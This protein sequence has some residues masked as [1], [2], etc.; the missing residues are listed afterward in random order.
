VITAVNFG[1]PKFTTGT[2]KFAD[3]GEELIRPEGAI[4]IRR[5]RPVD[6]GEYTAT[7]E[8]GKPPVESA[9]SGIRTTAGADAHRS[10]KVAEG[11]VAGVGISHGV[12]IVHIESDRV[13]RCAIIWVHIGRRKLRGCRGA[14]PVGVVGT[15]NRRTAELWEE[16]PVRT[17]VDEAAGKGLSSVV[18]REVVSRGQC[19]QGRG[20]RKSVVR[21]SAY[22]EGQSAAHGRRHVVNLWQR[23][24]D[25][26]IV[27]WEVE[28]RIGDLLV[29][30]GVVTE[31]T[32]RYKGRAAATARTAKVIYRWSCS[33]GARIAG[34]SAVK[35]FGSY[36]QDAVCPQQRLRIFVGSGASARNTKAGIGDNLNR[37]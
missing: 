37:S 36:P 9:G 26:V 10:R 25:A 33:P 22:S 21:F 13:R 4:A 2:Q 7:V 11:R 12:E 16:E 3:D 27:R 8:E 15:N 18:R 31:S 5:R 24:N 14:I 35:R 20:G 6:G 23:E 17:A 19:E 1:H 30:N 28:N 32:T 34:R 29:G